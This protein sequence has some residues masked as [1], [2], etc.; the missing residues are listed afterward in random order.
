[1][2]PPPERHLRHRAGE[3]AELPENLHLCL[4]ATSDSVRRTLLHLSRAMADMG[5]RRDTISDAEIVLAEV[6]NNVV[7]H[8]YGSGPPGKIELT[9]AHRPSRL[10]FV[11][12]DDGL[13]M[14]DGR[15]PEKRAA[16]IEVGR[17]DLP[18]GGFGWFLIHELV[19]DLSY[20]RKD[21]RNTVRIGL[22][23]NERR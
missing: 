23:L 16:C 7:E 5:I 18:E 6:M 3:T 2:R 4:T 21:G 15:L 11:V 13:P 19:E 10:D 8:A 22:A 12:V 9:V 17:G 20:S 1:M 14:P